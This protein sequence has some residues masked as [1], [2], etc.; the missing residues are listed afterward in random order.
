MSERIRI[1]IR[2]QIVTII[3]A[4]SALLAVIGAI[5]LSVIVK[6]RGGGGTGGSP[7]KDEGALKKWLDQLADALNRLAGMAV[8]DFP[9]IVGNAVGAILSFL[10]KTVGFVAEHTWTLIVF[11]AGLIGVWLMQKVSGKQTR[12]KQYWARLVFHDLHLGFRG[13]GNSVPT[14]SVL[15]APVQIRHWP[16]HK[17]GLSTNSSLNENMSQYSPGPYYIT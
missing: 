8:E 12:K 7:P 2:E 14:R 13:I 15:Y 11:V 1:L 6:F 4:V 17:R 9:A 5:V 3:S 16:L 10:G